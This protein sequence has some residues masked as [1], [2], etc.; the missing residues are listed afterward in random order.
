MKSAG[1]AGAH[2]WNSSKSAFELAIQYVSNI[3]VT[4]ARFPL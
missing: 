2:T 4:L 3:E 1:V